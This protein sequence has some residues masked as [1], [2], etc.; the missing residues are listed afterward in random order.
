[1]EPEG[2]FPHLQQPD[3]CLYPEPDQSSP[4]P[5]NHIFLKFFLKTGDIQSPENVIR[6]LD[7]YSTRNPSTYDCFCV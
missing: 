6:N 5:K 2:T 1:M 7:A 4:C 3:L